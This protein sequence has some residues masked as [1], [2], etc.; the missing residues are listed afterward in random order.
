MVRVAERVK[1][2]KNWREEC[3]WF[4]AIK[5]PGA[6]GRKRA[7]ISLKR[8]NELLLQANR[9]P[10]KKE[11]NLR[12]TLL[13]NRAKKADKLREIGRSNRRKSNQ[14]LSRRSISRHTIQE[15]F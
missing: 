2:K 14:E 13:C 1:E 15:S 7:R 4:T 3:R 6:R 5:H 12:Y 11:K 8:M 10:E 9:E